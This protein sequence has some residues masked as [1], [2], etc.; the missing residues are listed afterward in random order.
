M[1]YLFT[2][3]SVSEGHPDKISDQEHSYSDESDKATKNKHGKKN[4]AKNNNELKEDD[5]HGNQSDGSS[6]QDE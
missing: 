5:D 4:Q 3:E 2:S 6:D 1:A